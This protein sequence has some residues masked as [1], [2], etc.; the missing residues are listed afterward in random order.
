[1]KRQTFIVVLAGLAMAAM[2]CAAAGAVG[3]DTHPDLSGNWKADMAKSDFGPF[4]GPD[5][6]TSV[7][8]HKDP[9][10]RIKTSAKGG[11]R[12]DQDSDANYTTDGAECTNKLGELEIKTKA[13]WEGKKLVMNS[14]LNVQ[15]MD[16]KAKATYDLAEDGKVLTINTQYNTPQGEL[17]TKVVMNKSE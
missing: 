4:G 14:T 6:Q 13:A 8:E 12:G 2:S 10:L 7:I 17:A 5:S 3:D 1:M 16:I 9:K 15:G 11:P